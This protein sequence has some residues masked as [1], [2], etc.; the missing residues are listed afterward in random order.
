MDDG[1]PENRLT[2]KFGPDSLR[3]WENAVEMYSDLLG[4]Y[5]ALDRASR[6]ILE[7]RLIDSYWHLARLHWAGGRPG[8]SFVAMM[9][10]FRASRRSPALLAARFLRRGVDAA[11]AATRKET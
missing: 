4:R 2:R 7:T 9:G 8:K 6:G 3:R 10:L 1:A 11:G 5:P